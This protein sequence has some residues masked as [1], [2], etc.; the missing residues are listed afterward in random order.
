MA[1]GMSPYSQY[2]SV[3]M[4][5]CGTK[6]GLSMELSVGGACGIV[7]VLEM[8]P[9]GEVGLLGEHPRAVLLQVPCSVWLV[10]C[11]NG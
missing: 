2:S 7:Q 11:S 9:I 10:S 6:T 4:M 1:Y 3:G 5:A 8:L